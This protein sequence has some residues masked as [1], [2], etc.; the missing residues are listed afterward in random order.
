MSQCFNRNKKKFNCGTKVSSDCTSYEG[1]L[2]DWSYL[3]GEDCVSVAEV[4]EEQY[5][6]LDQIKTAIDTSSLGRMCVNYPVSDKSKI[7]V[8]MALTAFESLLCKNKYG[9]RANVF[10]NKEMS[11]TV[12]AKA[13]SGFKGSDVTYTVRSGKYVSSI[14]QD[15]AD[16]LAVMDL[17]EN[18]QDYANLHGEVTPVVYYND[19]RSKDFVRNDCPGGEPCGSVTYTV[20]AGKYSSSI[21]VN[22]ANKLAD[23]EIEK[24]GQ[25]NANI[26]GLCKKVYYNQAILK[27]FYKS[28]CPEGTADPEGYEYAV[29]TGQFKSTISQ[30]DADLQAKKYLEEQG[31]AYADMHCECKP[32][33]LNEKQSAYFH[34]SD[35]GVGFTGR[36][37][38]Y[39]I[40]AGEV[41]SFIS[42]EDANSEALSLLYQK[43][44]RLVELEGECIEKYW[45]IRTQVVP[46]GTATVTVDNTTQD[47]EYTE[48]VVDPLDDFAVD[49]VTVNGVEIDLSESDSKEGRFMGS[50]LTKKDSTIKVYVVA[51]ADFDISVTASSVEGGEI[52]ILNNK[53]KFE[54]GESCIIEAD[55]NEG[56]EF[57]GWYFNGV[58]VSQSMNYAFIVGR[59]TA[60]EYK[61][62]FKEEE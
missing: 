19:E 39:N 18:A 13:P 1:W 54:A 9:D 52:E 10:V 37:K 27:T 60:G 62:V 15:D 25:K 34:K 33:F 23:Q 11:R 20:P 49:Y 42:Q 28:E 29:K 26:Q 17:D 35:C 48:F 38:I 56:Y 55:P 51:K 22:E 45:N 5:R 40:E 47:G 61:A 30:L 8:A 59:T 3:K 58:L 21:S 46:S 44:K 24:E 53:P 2:P 57:L 4:L 41:R 14:S 50:F 36:A 32:Y 31:Q 12:S 43:G 6:V 16:N 7:T